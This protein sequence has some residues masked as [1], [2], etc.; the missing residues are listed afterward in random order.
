MAQIDH[1]PL[2]ITLRYRFRAVGQRGGRRRF[3]RTKLAA[4]TTDLHCAKQFVDEVQRWAQA[5]LDKLEQLA[6]EAHPD[7][8]WHYMENSILELAMTA[9]QA[10]RCAKE[11]AVAEREL[12]VDHQEGGGGQSCGAV[13][14]ACAP[15][16]ALPLHQRGRLTIGTNNGITQTQAHL[17]MFPGLGSPAFP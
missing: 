6:Q 16:S 5:N 7:P 9:F 10:R 11:E 15:G 2:R 14:A 12:D 17:C 1:A 4:A 8:S 13:G 3:D